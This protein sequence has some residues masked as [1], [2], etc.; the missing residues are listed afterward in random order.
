MTELSSCGSARNKFA[1]PSSSGWAADCKSAVANNRGCRCTRAYHVAFA[2][3][4]GTSGCCSNSLADCCCS[5]A[6][7]G[8]TPGHWR[9]GTA[10]LGVPAADGW[11]PVSELFAWAHSRGD[12]GFRNLPARGHD[13]LY[14]PALPKC[15]GYCLRAA[16]RCCPQLGRMSGSSSSPTRAADSARVPAA[17]ESCWTCWVCCPDGCSSLACS[18]DGYSPLARCAMAHSVRPHA[19]SLCCSQAHCRDGY[20]PLARCA[21]A[22]SVRPHADSLCCSQAHCP[23]GPKSAQRC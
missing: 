12:S 23:C 4:A 15:A 11:F 21:M 7:K 10:R 17:G 16:K 18:R 5:L 6:P 20:S 13:R 14:F 19:D 2:G 8:A 9:Q 22:H 3:A 1:A